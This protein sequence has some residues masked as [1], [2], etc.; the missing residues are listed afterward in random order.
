MEYK[1]I[2]PT[3]YPN[4][5]NFIKTHFDPDIFHSKEWCLVLK[6]AYSF[7][8]YYFFVQ[9]DLQ[10]TVIIPVMEIN[11]M[12]TGKRAVGLP[13]SDFSHPLKK[14]DSDLEFACNE[15]INL[16]Y[17][18]N[19]KYIELRGSYL[20][21]NISTFETYYTHDIDLTISLNDLWKKLKDNNKRNIKKARRFGL[22]VR[23]EN[24]W[25][26][27]KEF[28]KLQCITRKRHGL[29]PQPFKFFKLIFNQ[30]LTNDLGIIASIYYKNKMIAGAIF[31]LFNQKAI[32]KFGASDLAYQ[33]LRP[34][35]LIMWEAISWLKSTQINLLNLGRTA[36]QDTG[37]LSYKRAF[38]GRESKLIYYRYYFSKKAIMERKLY[39][40]NNLLN[41]IASKLPSGIL[42]IIGNISYRHL[43]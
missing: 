35:N 30:I 37:L 42:K 34:N 13:F 21:K 28:Y 11:S 27:L 32:F 33:I 14:S 22:K 8:P 23:F 3:I 26:S 5:N 6:S 15:I 25:Q 10:P 4:W 2:E 7:I 31:F 19:W 24:S 1:I 20:P 18:K 9:K 12:I 16:G 29:P 36:A 17:V 41:Q 38:S 39:Q 43:A 40:H